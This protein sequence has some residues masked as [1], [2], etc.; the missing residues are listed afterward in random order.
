MAEAAP[1][2]REQHGNKHVVL[3]LS[4]KLI[5]LA[6]F[7]LLNALSEFEKDRMRVVLDSINR[8][9]SGNIQTLKDPAPYSASLGSLLSAE[10]LVSEV[11]SLF[12]S[13]IPA[14]RSEKIARANMVR[15][16]FPA[17]AL[18]RPG[19]RRIRPDRELLIRRLAKAL[20]RNP[21]GRLAYELE[22]LHGVSAPGSGTADGAGAPLVEVGRAGLLAQRLIKQG[23][24]PE[25]LA[26]GLLPGRPDTVQFIL[27]VRDPAG[28]TNTPRG[29]EEDAG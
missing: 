11:G 24:P 1:S 5:L 3:L 10:D 17:T 20:M 4:L 14:A 28:P 21:A 9:F 2:S 26:V 23:L 18:F 6:F 15:V 29:S 8:T 27:H 13:I 19:E 25:V 16:V 22:F 7:I 12:E